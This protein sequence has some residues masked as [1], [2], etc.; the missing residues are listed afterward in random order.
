VFAIDCSG[1]RGP[2]I[3]TAKQTV[4]DIVNQVAK[5]KPAPILRIGLYGYGNGDRTS[6]KFDLSDDLDEVYKNLMAF[7][8]EGWSEEYVGFIINKATWDLI[9]V[10]VMPL[11]PS[12]PNSYWRMWIISLPLCPDTLIAPHKGLNDLG[13]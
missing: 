7:K 12:L 4:W 10:T 5:A 13:R 2:V 11:L 6:G 8:D 3:E 9:L 1:S